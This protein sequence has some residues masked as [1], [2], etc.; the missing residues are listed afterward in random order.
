MSDT[1]REIEELRSSNQALLERVA[2]LEHRLHKA[3]LAEQCVQN[4]N[5]TIEELKV[6]KTR[7]RQ[8]A[9]LLRMMCDNVPD[10]IWA[11]DMDNRYIFANKA[12]CR[13]LLGAADTDEPIGNDDLFFATRERSMH[14]DNPLWHTFGE[15]CIDS[16]AAT[17]KSGL[18][19][20]FDEF[21]NVRGKFLFLDV[22][23][24]P[25]LNEN[26]EV[27]GTV[28][29]A[30]DVTRARQA[31]QALK[32]SRQKLTMAMELANLSYWEYDLSKR[33]FLLDER[34][35]QQHATNAEQ[36]GGLMM[37]PRE[38]ISR[39]VHPDDRTRILRSME[40]ALE[41]FPGDDILEEEYRIIRRDGEVR[42]ILTRTWLDRDGQG[43]TLRLF[44]A[45][46]D[47]TE[48]K[49]IEISLAEANYLLQTII[50]TTP[51]RV[52]WKDTQSLYLGCNPA[53]ARDAGVEHP[54]D[55]IGK[56]DSHFCWKDQAERYRADDLFVMQSGQP[57]L[58]Y[59]ECQNTPDGQ[60]ICLR[61]SKVPLRNIA[62][63]IIGILGVYEDITERVQAQTEKA[64]LEALNQQL[65]KNESLGRMAG[66]IAHHFNNRLQAVL[67]NLELAQLD[68]PNDA[69]IEENIASAINE[70]YRAAEISGMMLSYLGRKPLHPK[71]YDLSD[72][73]RNGLPIIQATLT[74]GITLTTRLPAKGPIIQADEKLIQQ[75]LINLIVNACEASR[76]GQNT[77]RL[78]ISKASPEMIPEEHRFPIGWQPENRLYACIKVKDNGHGIARKNISN[79]FD[80]FFSDKFTGR[81]MGL[82]VSLGIISAHG[83]GI[84]VNSKV[85]HGSTFRV[86]IP[87]LESETGDQHE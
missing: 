81:G 8:L 63:E 11:K 49:R 35:Y 69:S 65:Q 12:I 54:R 27:I 62:N 53:F 75:V 39:F 13:D 47:I 37:T 17:I 31:E 55:M 30:R 45:N 6:N 85:S 41:P 28:G 18:A 73:C 25:F 70:C 34:F 67:G 2:E 52:F 66:A 20:Q 86:Y 26:G 46:Q 19:Q 1:G 71:T 82:S 56:D 59:D 40:G 44:G 23:K 58:S 36:E 7:Y 10:M 60:Q 5:K 76:D 51:I 64:R 78:E 77:I 79:I 16:D 15:I 43:R 22:H 32:D 72:I 21:G 38:Y 29:S 80:P 42:H 74:E 33:Q 24:A 84:S 68:M 4:L 57:R 61:T 48:R 3:E 83:G 14:K 50:N 87:V 9:G